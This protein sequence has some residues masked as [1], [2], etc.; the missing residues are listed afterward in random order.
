MSPEVAAV[1]PAADMPPG[2]LY[3]RFP[4]VSIR[5]QAEN[6]ASRDVAAT[7]IPQSSASA[8][9]WTRKHVDPVLI[10]R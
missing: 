5:C 9:Y 3:P 1:Y 8:S 2:C 4:P 10:R 6:P 7:P